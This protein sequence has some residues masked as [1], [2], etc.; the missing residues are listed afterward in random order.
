MSPGLLGQH[1]MEQQ[2]A[3]RQDIY[4]GE[5][6]SGMWWQPPGTVSVRCSLVP[7]GELGATAGV[8]RA[9]CRYTA[10]IVPPFLCSL[11]PSGSAARPQSICLFTGPSD[12]HDPEGNEATSSTRT[13][14][15]ALLQA[16]QHMEEVALLPGRQLSALQSI[17]HLL[18]PIAQLRSSGTSLPFAV[19]L[20]S[21]P[22][23][24]LSLSFVWFLSPLHTALWILPV[25][26][27]CLLNGT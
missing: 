24:A 25:T 4:H 16:L 7:M 8:G 1:L 19:P 23:W 14:W 22:F 12:T 6:W 15:A 21:P 2:Q 11:R 10:V 26:K 18:L 13:L 3:E 17:Q 9:P 5:P 27:V 20:L